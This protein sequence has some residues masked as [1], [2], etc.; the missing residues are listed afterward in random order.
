MNLKQHLMGQSFKI[1]IGTVLIT[2][3]LSLI[4][5]KIYFYRQTQKQSAACQTA[6]MV[7]NEILFSGPDITEF[8]TRSVLL[9]ASAG[10]TET[11]LEPHGHFAIVREQ[12]I[13]ENG[14][15]YTLLKLTPVMQFDRMYR[16]LLCFVILVFFITFFVAVTVVQAKN[17]TDIVRPLLQLKEAA[18]RLA[19]G[20]ISVPVP[21]SGIGETAEL[22]KAMEDLR[23]TLCNSVQRNKK[24]EE[25]R[26]F[27][28][29]SISH[30][31]KTPV[32]AVR[33]Y[34]EGVLDGV[35]DTPDKQKMYLSKA[36]EKTKMLTIMIEDLLLY[37][38]LDTGQVPFSFVRVSA[39][40]FM[41]QQIEEFK[42]MFAEQKRQL[43]FTSRLASAAVL[44]LDPER[45]QRV[46]QNIL[47]NALKHTEAGTGVVRV[48]LRETTASVIMEFR[49]N[50][51]GI[52]PEDLPHVFERFYRADSARTTGGGSGLGLAIAH[53]LV[54]GMDGRIWAVSPPGE[55]CSILISMKKQN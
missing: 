52:A 54:T 35:A 29:S 12:Y 20:N 19:A 26:T 22:A 30:D 44:R 14:V 49:D 43:S 34:I 48:S 50:G 16:N 55:G 15:L 45:F 5:G 1:L 23:L 17:D 10:K 21:E 46:V 39:L 31:L 4:F 2:V 18:D 8:E 51:Q 6:L 36:V 7:G 33:G 11:E 41:Q 47:T 25:D 27:L 38:R 32:T 40:G 53:Q 24:Y 9:D 42:P 28:L 13:G 3:C 37:S